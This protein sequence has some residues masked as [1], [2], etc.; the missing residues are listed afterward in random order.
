MANKKITDYQLISAITGTVN[1]FV[2]DLTQNYRATAAQI[3]DFVLAAGN[4]GSTALADLSVTT[5][6]I[7]AGAITDAKTNFTPP[8]YQKFTS[9]SGTYTTPAGVKYIKV[10]VTGGGGGGSGTGG[11]G[12]GV[13]GS[14]STFGTSLISSPGGSKGTVGTSGH[15]GG[16]GGATP[17]VNSPAISIFAVAGGQGYGYS[18]FYN[19]T[20]QYTG[21]GEGGV[22]F[23]GGGFAASG[24]YGTGGKGGS[25]AGVARTLGNGGGAGSTAFAQINSPSATYSYSVGA[26]GAGGSSPG[27]SYAGDAGIAG[28][29]IVEEFYQ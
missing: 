2:D 6:K 5:A 22:S 28:V 16:G 17:T 20:G 7:A 21:G 13:D 12:N 29:I 3:K 25:T 9:G 4:V 18:S 11:G 8:T 24:I 23:F 19:Q 1:F 15:G 10:Y 14:T 27:D 26:G